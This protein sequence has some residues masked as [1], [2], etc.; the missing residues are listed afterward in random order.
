MARKC[1]CLCVLAFATACGNPGSKGSDDG[2]QGPDYAS[3]FTGDWFGRTTFVFS[4]GTEGISSEV[5]QPIVATGKNSLLLTQFC[6]STDA[7][8]Q[9]AVASDTGFSVLPYAC[10]ILQDGCV[11]DFAFSGGSG[12]LSS[13]TLTI[14]I[15]GTVLEAVSTTCQEINEQFNFTLVAT[16]TD[17]RTVQFDPP[18]GVS[19]SLGPRFG[20]FAL[21]WTPPSQGYVEWFAATLDSDWQEIELSDE[22]PD[23]G[24]GNAYLNVSELEIIRFAAVT[25][26]GYAVSAMTP[27]VQINSAF[28][29]PYSL[30][31]LSSPDF[32]QAHLQW[33]TDH[34]LAT[35]F[36][37]ERAE[38]QQ[39]TYGPWAV[40]ATVSNTAGEYFDVPPGDGKT[41]AYRGRWVN[42]TVQGYPQ[43]AGMLM[44]T[45]L[46]A[47]TNLQLTAG[48]N[49]VDLQWTN[50]SALATAISV[51]RSDDVL[52][53]SPQF[54]EI[55]RLGPT[56]VAFHDQPPYPGGYTYALVA[57]GPAPDSP[58]TSAVVVLPLDPALGID[59]SL[60]D[61]PYGST[62]RR[63]TAGHW[64]VVSAGEVERTTDPGWVPHPIQANQMPDMA[65]LLDAAEQPHIVYERQV[66]AGPSMSILHDWFDGVA[67]HSEDLAGEQTLDFVPGGN[68]AWSLDPSGRPV[69]VFATSSLSD[70][71]RVIRWSGSSFSVEQPW[72]GGTPIDG[73][74]DLF[75]GTDPSGVVHLVAS[76]G[77]NLLY[78]DNG[79]GWTA[80]QLS[81]G[82]AQPRA[83]GIL[84]GPNGIDV[85]GWD[86]DSLARF[87]VHR[88]ASTWQAPQV[89]ANSNLDIGL[90]A[91]VGASLLD[92]TRP[93]ALVMAATADQLDFGTQGW[94]PLNLSR[95]YPLGTLGFDRNGKFY[96]LL[97][98]GP[99]PQNT[100]RSLEYLER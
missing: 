79:T 67:W 34:P 24:T 66:D 30:Q 94:S 9:A 62:P 26:N 95:S 44:T 85:L 21:Q 89:L 54:T 76:A 43:I 51:L 59:V 98:G 6:D 58:A 68:V 27:E 60:V 32:L 80:T 17:P 96:V 65:L 45:A 63:D 29:Q 100:N 61:L 16:R 86:A 23:G 25:T 3:N 88:D 87:V 70:G 47:P 28:V 90:T 42:D 20:V 73:V 56:D 12:S 81:L 93:A 40:L 64:Y 18:S 92:G 52:V 38:V 74:G 48:V 84:P 75:I 91:L 33:T 49:T 78:F 39:G 97:Y 22:G 77:S 46:F 55:A 83:A 31:V 50:L 37:V 13:G 72:D 71:L 11:Q 10:T 5:E 69:V 4:D 53:D 19:V 99:G 35:G 1:A 8:P 82:F 41:Y 15:Q 57:H 36:E 14:E 7:G 2:T